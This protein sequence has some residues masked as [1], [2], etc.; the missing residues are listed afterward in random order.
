MKGKVLRVLTLAT[1]ALV[2]MMASSAWAQSGGGIVGV[3]KDASGAVLPGVNVEATSPVLLERVRSV[4]TDGDGVY[5]ITDLRP[6]L[7]VVTFTLPGFSTVK[8]DGVELT[9]TFTATVNAE[10]KLGALEESITV[11]GTSPTGDVTNVVQ[12]KAFTR[13]TI[14]AL[15]TGSR[16]WA[17]VAILVPGVRLTGAQN[18]GGT[19]SSNATAS[20][21]GGAGA[22]AIMLLDGMRYHQGA[23][24]GGVRNAY[25][26]NDAAVEEITFQTASL[27]AETEAGS[28]VRNIVPKQGGNRFSGVLGGAFTNNKLQSN[29]LD[30]RLIDSGVP[31]V[32]FV[33]KIWD[34]NPGIGGP[35]K[36]D[37][38][39]FYSAFR[40][41]GVDQGIAGTYFNLTPKGTKYTPDLSR[42]AL[43]TSSKGSEQT[44]LTWLVTP[45]NK[46]GFYYE[47]QQNKENYSYGQGSLGGAATTP[48]ESIGR[49][50]VE[51]NYWVQ[52]RW[53][54]TATARLLFEAGFTL[55]NTNFQTVPQPGN[56]PSLPAFRELSTGTVWRNLPGQYGQTASHQ[57]NL[58]GSATYVTGSHNI[59]T[60]GLFLGSTVHRTRN[61][62]GGA[63]VLQL[64]NGVPASVQVYAMPLDLDGKI[65]G[66]VGLYVQDN[67]KYRRANVYLGGR[68]DYYKAHVEPGL[69]KP[70]PWVPNRN[71]SFDK[72]DN[73]PNWKDFEPRLG[74][75]YDLFGNG[76]TALKA[77]LNKYVFGP[78]LIVFTEFANPVSA[79]ATNATRTWNDANGDFAA[80]TSELGALSAATFGTPVVTSRYD[81]DVLNGW[82]KRGNNWEVSSS[83][84][85]ELA[86]RV[87]VNAAYFHRWWGNLLVS[88]NRAASASDF[89]SYC[90]TSPT[91]A[92]LPGGGGGQV[93]GMT[94]VNPN[95]F[96]QVDQLVTFVD[97]FGKEQRV[98]DG[99]DLTFNVRLGAGGLFGG[100]TNTERIRDNFCYSAGDPSLGQ[101]S[102]SPGASGGVFQAGAPRTEA[103]CDIRPP[104]L[105]QGKFYGAYPLPVWGLQASAT[106]QTTQGPEVTAAYTAR[107]TEIAPSLKRNL[108][109][110]ANGT[111]VV[112]LI[113]SGTQY[114]ERLYQTDFRLMRYFNVGHGKLQAQFD[115][116]NLF[117]DNPIIAQ[118]NT[119]G[120]A[121]QRGTVIQVGRLVKFGAQFT[122]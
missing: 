50:E 85:H 83:V 70:G 48:P 72:V 90:I 54:N 87:S 15:P 26:E 5:A 97:N 20:V 8:R 68:F 16:S 99:V 49:Y 113:P 18:V 33:D 112:A 40:Y 19:A 100:G 36:K 62:T 11:S 34:I 23:G 6:G 108:S 53:T 84:Q 25:N 42:Q 39:W 43:S 74:V 57:Y 80:Q 58:S 111:A 91:D 117:N 109:A 67:W 88:K 63:T 66:Q 116:Y 51:P 21:H 29:N 92:R 44:R 12:Q 52:S 98:Y 86:P 65:D 2:T 1:L 27:S 95:K 60:G 56:D 55:A 104:F 118:N 61:V 32:N 115:I 93:C 119:F 122:F 120:S 45:K 69:L 79:I 10:L 9:S 17:S 105:T 31:S 71:V 114:G 121:W 22:E 30:Q 106:F 24:F 46:L 28:F 47:Y 102:L 41:F 3:V 14:E 37:K 73:V 82:G 38:L 81:P 75:S 94:D 76:K 107:N 77:T 64:L 110:G 78:D 103:Y 13:E 89:S 4:T 101:L 7:Y 96:G 35:I 59:K